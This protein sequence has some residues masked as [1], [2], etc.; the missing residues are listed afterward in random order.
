[1]R[2]RPTG[3]AAVLAV[4]LAMP[5]AALA[6]GPSPGVAMGGSGAAW[7]GHGDRFVTVSGGR[8][9]TVVKRVGRPG[10]LARRVSGRWGIP[11]VAYDGATEQVPPRSGVVVLARGLMS[12]RRTRFLVVSARTLRPLHTV[13]LRGAWAFDAL[14]P[15]GAT[16]YLIEHPVSDLTRYEVRA[17]DVRSGRVLPGVIADRTSGEWRMEGVPMARLQRPGGDWSYTFYQGGEDGA[18]VHALDTANATA[19]CIDLP[20]LTGDLSGAA[21]RQVGRRLVISN[22]RRR[23]AAIDTRTLTVVRTHPVVRA[24]AVAPAPSTRSWEAPALAVLVLAGLA[25]GVAGVRRRMPHNP[26]R[27]RRA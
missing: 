23:L 19:R 17:L 6:V 8:G 16:M 4:G 25:A 12:V 22:G 15:D 18:F 3:V 10:R 24:A 27:D 1:M 5:A 9:S 2:V 11:E 13:S 14:S 20:G 7:A 26:A 21:L